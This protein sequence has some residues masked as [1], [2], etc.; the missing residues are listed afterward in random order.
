MH[1]AEYDVLLSYPDYDRPNTVDIIDGAGHVS[2]TSYG[3]S[4]V[5][6]PDEQ[7]APGQSH[8]QQAI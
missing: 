8:Q 4:K 7:G 5:I 2:Y 3:V 1:F 6:L